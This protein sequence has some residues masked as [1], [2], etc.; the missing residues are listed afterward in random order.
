MEERE[1]VVPKEPKEVR[2]GVNVVKREAL[3]ES[4]S[5]G[6][7]KKKKKKDKVKGARKASD[8]KNENVDS[9][10]RERSV[11]KIRTKREH[12]RQD[13]INCQN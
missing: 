1:E 11:E 10:E 8:E 2:Y 6:Y 7:C 9:K 5:W 12:Q 4:Q 13:E 3:E